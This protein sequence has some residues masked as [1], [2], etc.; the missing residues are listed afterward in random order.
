[1]AD[2][3]L[4]IVIKAFFDKAS[5]T[6]I[7]IIVGSFGFTIFLI[8]S[9]AAYIILKKITKS[10]IK[11]EKYDN[12][13][14]SYIEMF[15]NYNK[16][17]TLYA[18]YANITNVSNQFFNDI[19]ILINKHNSGVDVKE[20]S[21]KLIHSIIYTLPQLLK[22][23]AGESHTCVLWKKSDNDVNMEI[24]FSSSTSSKEAIK[25]AKKPINKSFVGRVYA[26][27]DIRNS[28]NIIDD[29]EYYNQNTPNYK[30]L[31]GI[32]IKRLE[33]TIA[34]LTINGKLENSFTDEDIDNITIFA[35]MLSMCMLINDYQNDTIKA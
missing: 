33:E 8:L 22:S 32:P 14:D 11:E 7:N 15:T 26:T 29:T 28:G 20:S 27:G 35:T 16:I 19:S 4:E 30:S 6:L 10:F 18:K 13:Q 31:L 34:V 2:T 23:S 5:P 1:M 9:I 17:Y 24:I 21:E 25:G 3:T 12:L